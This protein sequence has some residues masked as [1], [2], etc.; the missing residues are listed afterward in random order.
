M[1]AFYSEG[2]DFLPGAKEFVPAF[3]LYDALVSRMIAAAGF[4]FQAQTGK[5]FLRT[6]KE[7]MMR[8]SDVLVTQGYHAD[9]KGT[10]CL[11]R[12]GKAGV[13]ATHQNMTPAWTAGHNEL[14]SSFK[15]ANG[16]ERGDHEIMFG[17]GG[18]HACDNPQQYEQLYGFVENRSLSP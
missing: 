1:K 14:K 13:R 7:T 9:K 6:G 15:L 4:T 5:H 3:P 11:V 8:G 18:K 2:H 17:F 16:R 12:N 10:T